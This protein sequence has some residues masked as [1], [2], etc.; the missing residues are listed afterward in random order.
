[1]LTHLLVRKI[2]LSL[3]L[4]F[5]KVWLPKSSIATCMFYKGLSRSYIRNNFGTI[6]IWGGGHHEDDPNVGE[7][8]M[9]DIEQGTYAR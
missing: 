3:A 5:L 8:N 7:V 2:V 1:M 9:A 6:S 4:K